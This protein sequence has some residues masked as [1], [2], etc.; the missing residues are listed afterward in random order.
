MNFTLYRQLS[1]PQVSQELWVQIVALPRR[2]GDTLDLTCNFY[3]FSI[4]KQK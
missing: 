4:C 2:V 3:E 1:L